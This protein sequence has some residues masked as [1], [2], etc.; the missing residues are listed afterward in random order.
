[1]QKEL[2]DGTVV[3]L[4]DLNLTAPFPVMGGGGGTRGAVGLGIAPQDWRFRVQFPIGSLEIFK[5]C[6]PSV[7]IQ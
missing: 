5:W 6:I 4:F 2:N 3:T 7:R 1:M